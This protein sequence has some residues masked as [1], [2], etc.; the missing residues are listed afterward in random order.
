LEET[1]LMLVLAPVTERV[2]EILISLSSVYE[3]IEEEM[4]NASAQ[5]L[6]SEEK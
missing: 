1:G 4:S 2:L 6:L 5:F 3:T